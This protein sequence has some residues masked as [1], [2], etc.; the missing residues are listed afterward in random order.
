MTALRFVHTADL[1]LGR[2]FGGFP[3]ADRLRVA[4]RGLIARLTDVARQGG[5]P[6]V[7]VAGDVFETPNPAAQTWRQAVAEMAEA[8]DL[9]WWL[10][11]GNHDNLAAARTTWEAIQARGAAN[12]RVLDTAAPVPLGEHA[13]LLPAPLT[14]RRPSS[15]PTA[16]MAA[17]ETP[18]GIV[19]IGL[20][21]GPVQGFGE[22]EMPADVVAPDRDRTAAL[23]YLALGDWHGAL[24]VSDR[25]HY[26]GTP[27]RTGFLHPGR[28]TCHVVEI[29]GA[30]SPPHVETVETG[31][32]GWHRVT[33]DL[34]P[35]DDPAAR[36]TAALPQGPRRDLLVQVTA[37][38]R[39]RL[40]DAT[41]LAAAAEEIGPEFC[42]FD[43]DTTALSAEVDAAD[44]DEIAPTGALRAAST[45][46]AAE[47]ADPALS[48][49][50]RA[51]AAAALRRLHALVA[52][53]GR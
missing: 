9:T 7:L 4:R 44:L 16:W 38:G 26:A 23:D 39:L 30:G 14:V 50:D 41:A 45:E 19:R 28:G 47:A 2:P 29:A 43:L 3:E 20:A 40:G 18:P 6:H 25:V 46:L 1:H 36:L 52:E 32:F 34:V 27:E 5:A 11:P 51:L 12:I 8:A 22:G 31:V 13:V 24:R 37:Q 48:A 42:H 15:D 10:L 35:G 49:R 33:L 17:C 21:H 53:G